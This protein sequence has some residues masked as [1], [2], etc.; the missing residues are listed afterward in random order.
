MGGCPR[1]AAVKDCFSDERCFLCSG[2]VFAQAMKKQ[3]Q[4][5]ARR[6]GAA[7]QAR[8]CN[9]ARAAGLPV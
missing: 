9:A 7:M 4:D 1:L 8:V 3:V 5:R 6:I 2:S